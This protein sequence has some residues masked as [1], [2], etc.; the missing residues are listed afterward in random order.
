[1]VLSQYCALGNGLWVGF[2]EYKISP[3]V[4]YRT[5]SI[6]RCPLRYHSLVCIENSLFIVGIGPILS[7]ALEFIYRSDRSDRMYVYIQVSECDYI[8][9]NVT[10]SEMFFGYKNVTQSVWIFVNKNVT[11]SVL[12]LAYCVAGLDSSLFSTYTTPPPLWERFSSSF[13]F[14]QFSHWTVQI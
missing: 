6:P 14:V 11:Y 3:N 5:G 1:M 9:Q 8:N 10:Q 13:R 2:Q 7:K 4:M 12:F